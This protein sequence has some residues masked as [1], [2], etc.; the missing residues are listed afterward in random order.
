V[1]EPRPVTCAKA[2]RK[3]KKE[4]ARVGYQDW[5][6]KEK[7]STRPAVAARRHEERGE[8][9][10]KTPERGGGEKSN[11]RGNNLL[12]VPPGLSKKAKPVQPCLLT[13]RGKEEIASRQ[14]RR[15]RK[16][17]T[18]NV[19]RRYLIEGRRPSCRSKENSKSSRHEEKGKTKQLA[20]ENEACRSS[21]RAAGKKK[22]RNGG[23]T[24]SHGVHGEKEGG[25]DPQGQP[26]TPRV[27]RKQ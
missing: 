22:E 19:L 25:T 12:P 23:G 5:Q 2:E 15:E 3:K 14:G 17:E 6:G 11:G 9:E 27:V 20:N 13:E 4:W 8:G 16:G 10:E 1:N 7:G 18:E 24:M 21:R 26:L